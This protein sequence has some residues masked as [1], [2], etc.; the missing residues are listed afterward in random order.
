MRKTKNKKYKTVYL[1]HENNRMKF[2]LT[3]AV[4]FFIVIIIRILYLN[5]FMSSYYNMMLNKGTVKHVYGESVPRG[6][7]LDRNGN[8]LVD[9]KAIK[10]I[11][12]KKPSGITTEEEINIA[13]KI[14]KIL[15]LN[16]KDVL[17]RNLRE[18]YVII[19]KEETDKLITNEEYE[20]LENDSVEYLNSLK[21]GGLWPRRNK[22]F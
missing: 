10:T 20:K 19:N 7:I 18:F 9:N 21:W 2:I 1:K 5:I 15:K 6:R 14:S 8:V 17:D 16:Y 12:Y 11:Y 4:I 22:R 13:Y 3:F